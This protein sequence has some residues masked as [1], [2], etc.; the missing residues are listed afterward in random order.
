MRTL[1][2]GDE[3]GGTTWYTPISTPPQIATHASTRA[4][5]HQR[6]YAEGYIC[7]THKRKCMPGTYAAPNNQRLKTLDKHKPADTA[8]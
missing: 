4:R 7:P 2:P 8:Y 3:C 6:T 5:A 1:L